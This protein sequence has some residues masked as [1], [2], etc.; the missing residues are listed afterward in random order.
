MKWDLFPA[1][2]LFILSFFFFCTPNFP[3]LLLR[4]HLP[5]LH[6]SVTAG[7][8]NKRLSHSRHTHSPAPSVPPP[9][10]SPDLQVLQIQRGGRQEEEK[11]KGKKKNCI[12]PN[13]AS[14]NTPP[15]LLC[16]GMCCRHGSLLAVSFSLSL[17]LFFFFPSPSCAER[18]ENRE[19]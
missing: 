9:P 1:P 11:K 8:L 14:D 10:P 13:P 3:P 19:C 6:S 5:L 17:S 7:V 12:C 18:T 4:H 15:L 16:S 2:L